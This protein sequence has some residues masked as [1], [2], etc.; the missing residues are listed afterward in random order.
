MVVFLSVL[1]VVSQSSVFQEASI[2]CLENLPKLNLSFLS[3]P[4]SKNQAVS[5]HAF[6]LNS[7]GVCELI[8]GWSNGKVSL[9]RGKMRSC[10]N[11]DCVWTR[12][13]SYLKN[14]NQKM[15]NTLKPEHCRSLAINLVWLVSP[16]PSARSEKSC[17]PCLAQS[18][19]LRCGK[20]FPWQQR[21]YATS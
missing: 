10:R 9:Y 18:Q 17:F 1:S 19:L 8:T 11:R 12:L 2:W 7:D 14:S 3:C 20:L 13:L 6:D 4:Q 16:V 21:S 15:S 5:I